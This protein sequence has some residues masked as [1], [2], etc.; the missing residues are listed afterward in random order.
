MARS[1][2]AFDNAKNNH[3]QPKTTA[4]KPDIFGCR[5]FVQESQQAC[6]MAKLFEILKTD[7]P[8]FQLF[9]LQ[10]CKKA[11]ITD[12]NQSGITS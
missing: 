9:G 5:L 4:L 12:H 10:D 3:F 2:Y 8:V 1:V 11:S 6:C 7:F